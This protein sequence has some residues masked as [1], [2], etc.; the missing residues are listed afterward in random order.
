MS[1]MTTFT[2]N[3]MLTRSQYDT[4]TYN[5]PPLPERQPNMK[6]FEEPVYATVDYIYNR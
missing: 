6:I 3:T 2:D 4:T 5:I 1:N